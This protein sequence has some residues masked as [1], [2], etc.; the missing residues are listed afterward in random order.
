MCSS[1]LI[2][3]GARRVLCASMQ[4]E[5]EATAFANPDAST[6]LVATNRQNHAQ[7][8]TLRIDGLSWRVEL[9]A[10]SIASFVCSAP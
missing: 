7:H 1:D 4:A 9:P 2:R 6:V 3:P 8:F 5:V 10:R